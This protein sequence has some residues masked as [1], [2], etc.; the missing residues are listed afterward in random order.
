M[1]KAKQ[2]KGRGEEERMN[3]LDG[4]IMGEIRRKGDVDIFKVMLSCWDER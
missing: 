2:E 1:E 4:E 3:R